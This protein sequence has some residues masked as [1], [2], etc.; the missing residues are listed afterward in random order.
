MG[1][2]E[3][4]HLIVKQENIDQNDEDRVLWKTDETLCYF[5]EMILL[6]RKQTK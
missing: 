5:P 3:I 4:N 2:S 1:I 6:M